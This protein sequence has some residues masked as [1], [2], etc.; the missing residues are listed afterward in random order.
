MYIMLINSTL[1]INRGESFHEFFPEIND[2]FNE[3]CTV[4]KIKLGFEMSFWMFIEAVILNELFRLKWP[5]R[6]HINS[7]Y[8]WLIF[9][10]LY[11]NKQQSLFDD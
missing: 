5:A 10:R 4:S 2:C 11:C 7:P 6:L 9:N 3:L 8:N 1:D